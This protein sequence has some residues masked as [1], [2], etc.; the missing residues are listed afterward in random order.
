MG[1]GRTTGKQVVAVLCHK[2]DRIPPG[3][4]PAGGQRAGQANSTKASNWRALLT[5]MNHNQ[6]DLEIAERAA[7]VMEE[8]ANAIEAGD[9]WRPFV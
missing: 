4:P 6:Y 5:A 8:T 7:T 2:P 3:R 9:H 1:C